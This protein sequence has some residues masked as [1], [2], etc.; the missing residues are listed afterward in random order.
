MVV[1][2]IAEAVVSLPQG[3]QTTMQMP[4]RP[5]LALAPA[6]PSDQMKSQQEKILPAEKKHPE[7][8]DAAEPHRDSAGTLAIN[9]V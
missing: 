3:Q 5:G 9:T 8:R 7:G 4:P 1:S 6:K 2:P